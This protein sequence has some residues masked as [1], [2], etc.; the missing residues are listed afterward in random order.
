MFKALL[1]FIF[2]LTVN[3]AGKES[4][5]ISEG[6]PGSLTGIPEIVD[7]DTVRISGE[8]VRLEGMDAPEKRQNCKDAEGAFY[9][10]GIV[11]TEALEEVIG[12][13]AIVCT[14]EDRGFY[15]RI[16][17][18]CYLEEVNLNAWMVWHGHTVVDRRYSEKYISE[19]DEAREAK[20]GVW[21][22]EFVVP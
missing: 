9:P 2:T 3:C 6:D 8:S 1:L 15:G 14:D 17:G 5:E 22:G 11:A 19:E 18:T 16:I 4:T 21:Q 13:K 12:D 7:G 20:R 10:C